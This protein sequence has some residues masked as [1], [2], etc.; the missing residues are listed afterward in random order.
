METRA[1]RK[2]MTYTESID[3]K[4]R[5]YLADLDS[6]LKDTLMQVRQMVLDTDSGITETIKWRNSLVFMANKKNIIQTVVGKAHLTF[7]FFDGVQLADPSGLLEGEGKKNLSVRVSSM[8]FDQ[9][10]FV[11]LV[12]QAV[13]LPR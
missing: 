4:A 8:D 2:K 1:W 3:E 6:P 12:R 7:I 9:A 5:E 11:D 10:A 13:A